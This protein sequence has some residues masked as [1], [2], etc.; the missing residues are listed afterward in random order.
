M[1]TLF[2]IQS[3]ADALDSGPALK[4][5]EGLADEVHLLPN[6]QGINTTEKRNQWYA[7]I[8]DDEIIDEYL[9]EGLRIF[10][11]LSDAEM[12]VLVKKGG[13]GKYFKCPRL[14]RKDVKIRADALLPVKE[15]LALETVLNG[16]VH[17]NN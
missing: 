9:N 2:I 5:F 17:D 11:E 15:G 8:Y 13:E 10:I 16:F 1:L 12:L 14:F 3:R 6:I 4:S 7:V